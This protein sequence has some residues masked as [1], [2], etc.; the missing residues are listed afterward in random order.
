MGAILNEYFASVFTIEKDLVDNEFGEGFRD[1]LG[2]VEIKMEEVLEVLKNIKVDKSPGPDGV[3]PRILREARDEIVGAER[4]I[5]VS[6]LTT[7]E[8]PEDWRIA[9]VVLLFKKGGKDN[10]AN[11]RPVILTSV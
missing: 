2:H 5:F 11:Y 4:E 8:V 3:Y 1:S 7:G 6:L 9:T 10:P